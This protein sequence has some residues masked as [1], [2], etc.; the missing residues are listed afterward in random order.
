M[1]QEEPYKVPELVMNAEEFERRLHNGEKLMILD[2]LV[3]DVSEFALYHPGGKFVIE[4]TVG[5]DI[6]KFFYGGYSLEDNMK[7]T[8]AFGWRH[9]NYARIIA[10]DLAIARFDCGPDG[11]VE[12]WCRLRWDLDNEVNKLTRSFVLETLDRKPRKN[13][14]SY[15][16]GLKH[17]T[18]HFWIRNMSQPEVIR[19]YTTCNAM[20]PRFYS[21]LVRVLNN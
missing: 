11:S 7:P 17:L 2:D 19:H 9:S 3:L 5:T 8:P 21:E 13:Y 14:K 18:K 4:H 16:P 1:K 15:Y 10:N 20:A 6:A 12:S